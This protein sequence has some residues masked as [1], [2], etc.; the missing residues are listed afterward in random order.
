MLF[1]PG[2]LGPGSS[3]FLLPAVGRMTGGCHHAQLFSIQMGS[4][5]CFFFPSWPGVVILP[6][7]IPQGARI[8]GMHHWCTVSQYFVCVCVCGTGEFELYQWSNSTSPV[9]C[10]VFSR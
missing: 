1:W 9:L 8:T 2:M 4:H 3:Y 10:W 5:E 7:S 6:I